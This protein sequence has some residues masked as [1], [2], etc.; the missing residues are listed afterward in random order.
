MQFAE[1]IRDIHTHQNTCP[2]TGLSILRKPEWLYV[3][4]Q[5]AYTTGM[6][7]DALISTKATGYTD[8]AGVQN[9]GRIMESLFENKP[10]SDHRFIV[11]EDYSELKGAE[12]RARKLYIDFFTRHQDHLLAVIFYNTSF[13]MKL[14]VRLGRALHIVKFNV[15]LL[16]SY[17]DALR[18][19]G[20]LLEIDLFDPVVAASASLTNNDPCGPENFRKSLELAQGRFFL[21]IKDRCMVHCT[22]DGVLGPD[23]IEPVSEL[24]H[25]AARLLERVNGDYHMVQGVAKLTLRNLKARRQML[26]AVKALY[27]KHPFNKCIF[28]GADRILR[29]RIL[30]GS[31]FVPFKISLVDDFQG[32]QAT[33]IKNNRSILPVA[34]ASQ[35]APRRNL[36]ATNTIDGYVDE[37][38]NFVGSI[39]WDKEG[40]ILENEIDPQHPFLPVFD[41]I[42]L[43]KEDLDSLFHY[44]QEAEEKIQE[45]EEK[46]RRII[47]DINDA[48][49][50][51][52][53]QGNLTFYNRALCEL[54]GH[55]REDLIGLNYHQYVDP[56]NL[57]RLVELF[58]KVY[59]TGLPE[60]AIDYVLNRPDGKT[61]HAQTSVSLIK[62]K[63]GNPTGFRGVV[64]DISHSKK[65]EKEL[66][67]HRD[68]LEELVAD[69]TEQ[70]RRSRGVL[71]TILDSMPYGVLIVS[72]DK[73]IR[74][75]N[76][77]ALAM[78]GYD[79]PEDV[80]GLVCHETICPAEHDQCPVLDLDMEID[81]SERVLMTRKGDLIPI[82]KSVIPL[83]LDD[84]EVLLEAFIDITERK[85]AEEE[86][87]ESERKFRLL[88]ENLP[89]VVF[90]GYKDW[91]VEFYDE[92]IEAIVGYAAEDINAGRIQWKSLILPEDLDSVRERFIAALKSDRQYRREYRVISSS[93]EIRWVRERGQIICDEHGEIDY[94]SGVFFDITE[95]MLARR[96][97]KRSQK[98]A[99]AA[100]IA[101][102]EFLANMSHEIRTPL[103]GII[104]MAEL[105]MGTALDEDQ[106]TILETIDKESASLLDI[107]NN[108]LDFSKI[109]AGKFELHPISFNLRLLI[110]DVT[111]SIA[112]R[113]KNHGLEFASYLAPE[114]PAWLI[115]DAGRLRQILNNLAGNALKFTEQGA[116]TIRARIDQD[117]EQKVKVHFE[118]QDTGIGIPEAY[119][120]TIFESFTQADGST[121]RKYGGTGLGTTISKQLGEMMG[122]EIGVY[123]KE[124]QGSTFWFTALFDKVPASDHKIEPDHQSLAGLK[125]LVV[126][127]FQPIRLSMTEFL[128]DLD[129][130]V[131]EA[132]DGQ[133]ALDRLMV[134]AADHPF[135]LVLTDIRMPGLDGYELAAAIRGNGQL[136]DTRIIFLTGIG[137]IG[138]GKRCQDWGVDG[139]L[140]KPVKTT[141]LKKTIELV[142]GAARRDGS[143]PRNLVTRHTLA[144]NR[145]QHIR[146]LLAEDYP[147][148]QQVALHHLKRAGF[149]VD[150][151]EN[152]QAALDMHQMQAYQLILMDMQMP[153]MDGYEATKTIRRLEANQG[154]LGTE[155]VRVPIIAVTA[156][157]M[158]GDREKCLQV[159]ADD[160]I[161]KS[162]RKKDLLTMVAKWT[163]GTAAEQPPPRKTASP[164]APDNEAPLDLARALSEFD[165]DR[166]FFLEVLDGFL[167]NLVDQRAAI[168]KGLAAGD[169]SVI[170]D[171]AHAIKGGAANLTAESLASSAYDLETLARS[172]GLAEAGTVLEQL[173]RQVEQLTSYTIE[174]Q[175]EDTD[176]ED[177]YE[178]AYRG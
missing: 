124:S 13:P 166:D 51:V 152:G 53:L 142:M 122:G 101:K 26:A 162:L 37:L 167:A 75:A 83:V 55:T 27:R 14:S 68:N 176:Q 141:E 158:E 153:V 23:D 50:E 85:K 174:I 36:T 136:R 117:T 109:E 8:V 3:S 148:N 113:A 25:E 140:H 64:R 49:F 138:D 31:G 70:L 84:E 105:A 18:R 147:T 146:I 161:A 123:S 66:L 145:R 48:F 44:R 154:S 175:E 135:D 89:S 32:A 112:I 155:A 94:I 129:C 99:E 40:S 62:D 39:D 88:L 45:S 38:M 96:E 130:E 116:I 115:G 171:T 2:L 178:P 9:Y 60:R 10:T 108:V 137:T 90:R 21:E 164:T 107:I 28:Y 6:L 134:D 151:A 132:A 73:K 52:D 131:H 111:S 33:L 133:T 157:S 54:V 59:K 177:G 169:A 56:E 100:N 173:D 7:T 22:Y 4:N 125:I 57:P 86:L 93:G 82:L 143:L 168:D 78:M 35:Q 72:R 12:S 15:E 24:W 121:T 77:A 34:T 170:E 46:Y 165:D 41:A 80:D 47:E 20:Q 65:I 61:M 114:V 67:Q 110:E 103:N 58:K 69:Q 106:R 127:D 42:A 102:S 11:L 159:G 144:E 150:L 97:L 79:T 126:D 149:S 5:H 95:R 91:S 30:M 63:D 76:Q 156:H 16:G 71:Q 81:R 120:A 128:K 118:V 87:K 104:G 98:A 1:T 43:I 160:Y 119:L 74:Y 139:Y 172:G 29:A 17:A 19:A 92:K 163:G